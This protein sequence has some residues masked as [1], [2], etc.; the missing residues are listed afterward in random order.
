MYQQAQAAGA[1]PDMGGAAGAANDA[2]S[3]TKDDNV[4]DADYEV[5]DEDK[6]WQTRE[7]ISRSWD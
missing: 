5:V 6:K 2:G 7:I 1:N 3:A 4:V